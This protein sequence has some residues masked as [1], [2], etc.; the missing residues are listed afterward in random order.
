MFEYDTD[1]LF[2]EGALAIS[3]GVR[4]VLLHGL[5]PD[6][7]CTC[8]TGEHAK[9][10]TAEMRE[11]ESCSHGKH[12]VGNRWSADTSIHTEEELFDAIEARAGLPT[13]IGVVLGPRSGV[14]DIE[15][16]SDL[17]RQ[18]AEEIGLTK[19]ETP[20]Y[21]SGRSEHR[22]FRWDDA[23]AGCKA[24][25]VI[26][27]LEFR[28]GSAANA[29]SV[30]PPS[31][32]W[33]GRQ[34]E[35]KP[36]FGLEDLPFAEIPEQLV[37]ALVNGGT[38][39]VDT[40]EPK[41]RARNILH[42]KIGRGERHPNLLRYATWKVFRSPYYLQ[43]DEQA[44]MLAEMLAV[45][46]TQ[47]DPPKTEEQVA[48][49]LASAIDYRRRHDEAGKPTPEREQ[50]DEIAA[51]IQSGGGETEP[52]VTG[53][54]L[55][56]LDWRPHHD[57]APGEWF[58]GSWTIQVKKS[59]PPSI[60]LEVPAWRDTPCNGRIQFAFDEFRSATKVAN[61]VFVET[62]RV[63]LDDD[64]GEWETIWRG[65]QGNGKR[66]RLSG[67]VT[68]LLERKDRSKDITVGTSDLRH[69]ELAG[70]V[71]Q[72]FSRAAKPRNEENPEPYESGRP[73]WVRPDELWFQWGRL[74][75]EIINVHRGTTIFERNR[76]RAIILDKLGRDD[77]DH[78]RHRFETRQLEY[79]VFGP[80]WISTLE[81][82]STGGR[83]EEVCSVDPS[84]SDSRPNSRPNTD[85]PGDT[86]VPG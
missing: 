12:P 41:P 8:G 23:L 47:C 2:R 24:K 20:T 17:G 26:R 50:L 21:T 11:S 44:D 77:F 75:E 1:R 37:A 64:R 84:G 5:T 28:L 31:W 66:P 4:V 49:V 14:V 51:I 55:H 61:R 86:A 73:C 48:S 63:I 9:P 65:Q 16:D 79:V 38:P 58:P 27:G 3:K 67:L 7:R 59:D 19:I 22:L 45:N 81:W 85:S 69:A 43:A 53:L 34:Y 39:R 18:Y 29:Q 82:L 68:K 32:H 76:L 56:G 62:L 72:Q 10:P 25:V 13:N 71:L 15:W 46:A 70:Y 35:W 36:G 6:V 80:E 57:W 83:T 52:P 33:S 54:A 74:W 30:M 42:T 40:G 60:F 78:R